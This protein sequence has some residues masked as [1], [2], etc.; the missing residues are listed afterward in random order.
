MIGVVKG[1]LLRRRLRARRLKTGFWLAI[2]CVF[3]EAGLDLVQLSEPTRVVHTLGCVEMGQ[4]QPQQHGQY[5]GWQEEPCYLSIS[6]QKW[7]QVWDLG[8]SS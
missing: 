3:C 6:P 1:A 5:Q 4:G 7:M 8:Q 2:A